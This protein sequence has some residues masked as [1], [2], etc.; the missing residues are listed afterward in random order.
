MSGRHYHRTCEAWLAKLDQHRSEALPIL[1]DA[2]G[3]GLDSRSAKATKAR[4]WFANWRLFYLACSE[5]FRWS[6]GQRW[7]VSHYLFENR[8]AAAR[9]GAAAGGQGRRR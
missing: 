1:A 6:G 9:T 8:K 4:E 2:Y 7:G 5:L 3:A